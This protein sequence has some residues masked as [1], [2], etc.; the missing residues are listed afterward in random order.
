MNVEWKEV[1]VHEVHM[2]K[3]PCGGFLAFEIFHQN[4]RLSN[5]CVERISIFIKHL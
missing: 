1:K 3:V 2:L 4:T 5:K